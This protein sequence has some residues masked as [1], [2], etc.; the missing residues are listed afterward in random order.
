MSTVPESNGH[1][2][3]QPDRPRWGARRDDP[4]TED[5][6]RLLIAY[7]L[8]CPGV[9]D[10]A[11]A[12]LP[13]G[14]LPGLSILYDAHY[15]A[16]WLACRGLRARSGSHPPLEL[17]R[18]EAPGQ[19]VAGLADPELINETVE[20]VRGL[21]SEMFTDPTAGRELLGRYL[22]ERWLRSE[23]RDVG[24]GE[25]DIDWTRVEDIRLR[26]S[27]LGSG[28]R[29]GPRVSRPGARVA[30]EPVPWT[31][32][33]LLKRMHTLWVGPGKVMKS[34]FLLD[35][36][37]AVGTGGMTRALGHWQVSAP[38]ELSERGERNLQMGDT[39]VPEGER[40][41]YVV[42]EDEID[43]TEDLLARICRAR[44]TTEARCGV[45]LVYDPP[46][47]SHGLPEILA[48]VRENR[49]T[50]VVL[51]TASAL[52]LMGD[53]AENV[54]NMHIM[55]RKIQ[56]LCRAFEEVGAVVWICHHTTKWLTGRTGRENYAPM[57]REHTSGAGWAEAMK[58]YCM[59]N[60]SRPYVPG[61]GPEWVWLNIGNRSRSTLRHV[62]VEEGQFNPRTGFR[63][64]WVT[65]VQTREEVEA[66]P[67]GPTATASQTA[68]MTAVTEHL[69]VA[70][71][72][73]G[74]AD[75]SR[76]TGYSRERLRLPLAL[77]ARQGAITHQDRGNRGH[78]Y[79]LAGVAPQPEPTRNLDLSP[80]EEG[81]E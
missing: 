57:A 71:D 40:V 64:H 21:P 7:L 66:N 70:G 29:Q 13:D 68:I 65:T 78:Y 19:M 76:V 63:H 39:P 12:S 33:G 49:S 24:E 5:D 28:A 11:V 3:S 20:Y 51:D 47:L 67:T 43:E 74:T 41:L 27:R 46:S 38:L 79:R 26:I 69:T 30:A 81:V 17:V 42:G 56:G 58:Q 75:L 72:W 55:V 4:V 35:F 22:T 53:D 60:R 59:I 15:E 9:A 77:L 50:I 61:D 36:A 73:V 54:A 16:L 31:I 25:G 80:T 34:K 44:G 8:R 2:N 14:D 45:T 6:V 32:P 23:L 18:V 10:A 62:T 37:V 1:V 48:L 52:D